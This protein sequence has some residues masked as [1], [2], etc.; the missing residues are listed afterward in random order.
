MR[1]KMMMAVTVLWVVLLPYGV[2]GGKLMSHAG[3][4][5]VAPPPPPPPPHLHLPLDMAPNSVDDMYKGC[6]DEMEKK[7]V[8]FL[9]KERKDNKVFN[10]IWEKLKANQSTNVLTKEEITALSVYTSDTTYPGFNKAT[11][12]QG[13]KY[14]TAFK[15]HALHFYLTRAVQNLNALQKECYNVYRR[16][17]VFFRQDV[18]NKKVRFSSF[19]SSSLRNDLTDF[20]D[21]SC[22]EIETCMGADISWFSTFNQREVLIPPYEVFKVTKIT[23]RSEQPDLWCNVV[24]KLKSTKTTKSNLDCALI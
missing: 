16:T 3:R 23:K 8:D 19:A 10:E 6:A 24:Y 18:L 20:G 17:D 5:P 13:P 9:K 1:M 22:F 12:E 15:Y 2:S 21:K 14:K 7:A 4:K 11:R